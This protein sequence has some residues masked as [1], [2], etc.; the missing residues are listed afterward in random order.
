MLARVGWQDK[1]PNCSAGDFCFA[2]TF[3]PGK[4][5][6]RREQR[7]KG[8]RSREMVGWTVWGK[9]PKQSPCCWGPGGL[10]KQGRVMQFHVPHSTMHK[11]LTPPDSTLHQ[12]LPLTNILCGFIFFSLA[13]GGEDEQKGGLLKEFGVKP[14]CHLENQVPQSGTG[15]EGMVPVLTQPW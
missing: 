13:G 9:G 3:A 6:E 11:A 14:R 5:Q 8:M 4:K 12:S 10:K 2:E 15:I 7:W 1:K